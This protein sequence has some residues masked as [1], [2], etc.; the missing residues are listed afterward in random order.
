MTG[1]QPDRP[2]AA[3]ACS[4]TQADLG[5]RQ[6]RWLRLGERALAGSVITDNGL[7][8]IFRAAPGIETELRELTALER[9]CCAFAT[10]AVHN[11]GD[12]LALDVSVDSVEGIAAVQA[13]FATL[14]A[15]PHFR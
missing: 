11:H 3:V 10:W 13:M 2:E 1:V 5:Q 4:L 15:G 12:E 14:R 9:D 6:E 8:L 7:R